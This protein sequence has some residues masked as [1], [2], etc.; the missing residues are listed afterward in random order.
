MSTINWEN[1]LGGDWGDGTN[2]ELGLV[3][4]S[5]DNTQITLPGNYTVTITSDVSAGSLTINATGATLDESSAG[6]LNLSG[7]VSLY[8][9]A[10]F[11]TAPIRSVERSKW[12]AACLP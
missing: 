2:W 10:L 4:H 5:S 12:S 11:L 8:N 9:G 3:P 1:A 7:G 6:S